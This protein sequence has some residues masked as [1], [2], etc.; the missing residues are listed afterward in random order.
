MNLCFSTIGCPDWT[1]SDIVTTAK[2]LGYKGIEIRS[3]RGEVYAP[4][5][6]EFKEDIA[7]TREILSRTG[8][9]I[10]MLTSPCALADNNCKNALEQAKEY[11]SLAERL[12]VPFIRV[13][14]TD[15]PYFDGGDIELC[16]KQYSELLR[17]AKGSGVVPLMET[18]GIFADTRI[19]ADFLDEVGGDAGALWDTHHPYRFNDESVAATVANLGGRIKYVHLKDSVIEKGKVSYKM[20]GCGDIPLNEIIKTLKSN[21]YDGYYTFEWVKLWNRD[22]EDGGIVFAHF[23]NYMNRF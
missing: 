9:N 15:K 18:N 5:M 2:D 22:L 13:M 14:S 1:L 20:M 3:I 8:I 12:Q 4:S 23:A 17:H 19:L 10:A 6:K 21:G 11:V 16:K 7:K